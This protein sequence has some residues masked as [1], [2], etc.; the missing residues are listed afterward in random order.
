M[1]IMNKSG[2]KVHMP[3]AEED[4]SIDAG[5]AADPE[6]QELGAEFFAR[7]KPIAEALGA[8]TAGELVALRRPRGR[9]A[10]SVAERTKVVVSMRVDPDVLEALRSTGAGWQTRVNDLLRR[11]F[12]RPR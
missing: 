11:E 3:T 2:R 8:E 5:I 1:S 9:P 10:G 12:V 4:A 6:S 7:A